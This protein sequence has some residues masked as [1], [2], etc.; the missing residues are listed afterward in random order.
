[1]GRLAGCGM[2]STGP[3]GEPGGKTEDTTGQPAAGRAIARKEETRGQTDGGSRS[4]L[5]VRSSA[6]IAGVRRP[7]GL[8]TQ[9]EVGQELEAKPWGRDVAQ[10]QGRRSGTR[11][12]LGRGRQEK[13]AK[14]DAGQS[15]ER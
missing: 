1:M 11:T 5:W 6:W 14:T 9:A 2:E 7:C 15:R 12:S 8:W 13:V 10:G 4:L 3:S